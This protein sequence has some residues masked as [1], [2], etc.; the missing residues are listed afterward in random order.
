MFQG[1]FEWDS[2]AAVFSIVAGQ[3]PQ[4]HEENS[5]VRFTDASVRKKKSTHSV[6]VFSRAWIE[7]D[8][9]GSACFIRIVYETI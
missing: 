2:F 7:N 4:V 3:V 5:I 1:G 9:N 6:R 8:G